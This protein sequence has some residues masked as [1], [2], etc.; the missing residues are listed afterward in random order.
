MKQQTKRNIKNAA[1]TG[2]KYA[3]KGMKLAGKGVCA[4]TELTA[5]GVSEVTKSKHAKRFIAGATTIAG[6][7]TLLGPVITL[8]TISF[9]AQNM[10]LGKR[11]SP[12][13]ALKQITN[14][15][16]NVLEGVLNLV[17]APVKGLAQ[18]VEYVAK[19]GKEALDR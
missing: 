12:V 1:R 3:L 6:T 8:S 19:Q 15:S 4:L 11:V 10:L 18:G 5:K 13:G 7:V 14:A 2:G 17:T 9:L 16:T